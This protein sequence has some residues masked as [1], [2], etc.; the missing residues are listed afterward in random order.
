MKSS[1]LEHFQ[2]YT[3]ATQSELEEGFHLWLESTQARQLSLI[4]SHEPRGGCVMS[5]GTGRCAVG[6]SEATGV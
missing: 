1:G 5:R 6:A 4:I 3:V 2:P